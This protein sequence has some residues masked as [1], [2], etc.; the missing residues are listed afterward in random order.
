M[1]YCAVPMYQVPGIPMLPSLVDRV[2]VVLETFTF[3]R[4]I[5]EGAIG[6]SSLLAE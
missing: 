5:I 4:T 2:L 1:Q 3:L 6:V